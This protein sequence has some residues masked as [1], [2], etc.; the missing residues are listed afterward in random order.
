MNPRCFDAA[1]VSLTGD[2]KTNQ[3]RALIL[4]Q[5]ATT[6]LAVADGLGGHP[7][8]E[9]AAQLFVDVSE[10]LF[11][12]E[13]KPLRDPEQFM[14]RCIHKAHEAILAF[15]DR[16]SPPISPRTTAVM[17][18]MQC[19]IA[20]WVHVGDSRLYLVREGHVQAQTKDHSQVRFI[21]PAEGA[22]STARSSI[23][24]CLGGLDEPPTISVG[25]PTELRI[26]DSLLLCSDGLWGQVPQEDL[27]QALSVD[28]AFS[29]SIQDLAEDAAHRGY[30][31][32]DNVTA[33]AIRWRPQQASIQQPGDSI[34]EPEDDNLDAAIRHL[35]N[36]L[37]QAKN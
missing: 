30:P 10:A 2:R 7:R 14:M 13:D 33:L 29:T 17:A 24:R 37:K 15:G 8:G 28:A 27:L 35:R 25:S 19:G 31:R 36:V 12:Q 1:R 20:Y 26:G 5:G 6:L 22:K 23:T 32:S 4:S 3:D 9:V 16:Q 21:R 18:V 34:V 11:R